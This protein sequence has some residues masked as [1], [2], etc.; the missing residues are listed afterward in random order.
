MSGLAIALTLAA[1][2]TLFTGGFLF[3]AR[4]GRSRREALVGDLAQAS[5]QAHDAHAEL[6]AA[7]RELEQ[8]RSAH[9]GD[10]GAARIASLQATVTQLSQQL[11]TRTHDLEQIVAGTLTSFTSEASHRERTGSMREEKLVQLLEA[12]RETSIDRSTVEEL[13]KPLASDRS[14]SA[15]LEREMQSVLAP[16][17]RT[18]SI[19]RTLEDIARVR[20]NRSEINELL[21]VVKERCGLAGCVLA[22]TTGLPI[23]AAAG[24]ESVEL[25][26]GLS[27]FFHRLEER[28]R[29]AG[30]PAPNAFLSRDEQNQLILARLIRLGDETYALIVSLQGTGIEPGTFDPIVPAVRAA[31]DTEP[32]DDDEAPARSAVG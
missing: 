3:G 26:A 4:S 21:T 23:A 11:D 6:R 8:A 31:L 22:D 18:Q 25:V 5:Q 17:A 27:T 1:S 29:A 10:D 15:D 14:A 7:Q 13:L 19:Q 9:G 12:L 2:G 30:Q 24:S 32:W 16:L 28:T 20:R